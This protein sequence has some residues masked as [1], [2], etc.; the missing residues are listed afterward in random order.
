MISMKVMHCRLPTL[1]ELTKFQNED[2]KTI[3]LNGSQILI[4]P[5]PS[6]SPTPEAPQQLAGTYHQTLTSSTLGNE[7]F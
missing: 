2:D 5:A 3:S 7:S 6:S 4:D 1:I